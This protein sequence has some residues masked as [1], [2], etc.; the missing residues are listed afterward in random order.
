MLGLVITVAS[1]FEI[2]CRKQANRGETVKVGQTAHKNQI[3]CDYLQTFLAGKSNPKS[4][5]EGQLHKN[6]VCV[7]A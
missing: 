4:E 2:S 3:C 5:N 6:C 7:S 1:A